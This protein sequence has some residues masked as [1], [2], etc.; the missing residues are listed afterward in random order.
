LLQEI[1]RN[2]SG[3]DVRKLNILETLNVVLL[4]QDNPSCLPIRIC[5]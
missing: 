4:W 5:V 1:D 3:A 2:V